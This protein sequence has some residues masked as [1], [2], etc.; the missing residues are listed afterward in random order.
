MDDYHKY[1]SENK[2]FES[3][4][5]WKRKSQIQQTKFTFLSALKQ[6]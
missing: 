6:T 3:S 5:T 4:C 1:D 2:N